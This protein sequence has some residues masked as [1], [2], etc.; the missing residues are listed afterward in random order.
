[1]MTMAIDPCW[2]GKNRGRFAQRSLALC[3][4]LVTTS[5]L[6]AP[7]ARAQTARGKAAQQLAA[8]QEAAEKLAALKS[9]FEKQL[10]EQ[11]AAGNRRGHATGRDA[12][13]RSPAAGRDRRAGSIALWP[14]AS[15][16]PDTS[17]LARPNQS[18]HRLATQSGSLLNSPGA[19]GRGDEEDLR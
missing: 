7:D 11:E 15:G 2:T 16:L 9:D 14:C 5:V 13:A 10:A 1:M 19:S 17:V 6:G 4:A 12:G 8:E 3:L 18:R